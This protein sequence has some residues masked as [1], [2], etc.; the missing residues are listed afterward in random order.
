MPQKP[1]T[2][3]NADEIE[4]LFNGITHALLV[5]IKLDE[6]RIASDGLDC[7]IRCHDYYGRLP[8]I[9]VGF[10]ED[11][12]KILD[13]LSIKIARQAITVQLRQELA[14][15]HRGCRFLPPASKEKTTLVGI[16]TGGKKIIATGSDPCHA[17]Q[18][19]KRIAGA[20]ENNIATNPIYP[21]FSIHSHSL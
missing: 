10:S 17:Y 20:D 1:R 16:R 3:L 14:N 13:T 18:E 8:N 21:E 6:I 12:E 4:V 15:A 11:K 7:L 5:R 19:L 2:P 9:E